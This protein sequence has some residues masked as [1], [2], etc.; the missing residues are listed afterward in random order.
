MGGLYG[1]ILTIHNLFGTL[2][3]LLTLIAGGVLLATAR[4]G[5]TAS[6]GLLRGALISVS[7]QFLLGMAM[8]LIA[9]FTISVE[10]AARYWLHYLLG[11]ISVGVVSAVT[12]RA[13]RAPDSQAR[14]YGGIMLGVAVLVLVTFLVGQ[15]RW[16]LI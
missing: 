13:R 14:R 4:T 5:T 10:Y 8:V 11:F 12:A 1:T 16:T 3:L 15:F 2:T 7:I 6:S 9:I